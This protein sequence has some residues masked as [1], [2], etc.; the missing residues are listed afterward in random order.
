MTNWKK[1]DDTAAFLANTLGPPPGVAIILGSGLGDVGA[2]LS[3]EKSV[4]F[5]DIPGWPASTVVGHSGTLRRG[6]LGGAEVA[7]QLG[8][9]HLY[10][11]YDPEDVVLPVRSL[12]RWGAGTIILT[13]AAGGINENY[14]AG[15][16]MVVEDHLNLTGRNPL[17]GPNDDSR[18][19]RFPDMS[20]IYDANL[21]ANALDVA[22]RLDLSLHLGVY[23]GLTGPSYETPAEIR[24]LRKLGADAVGMSTVL[25]AI[26]AR[27]L[28]A[29]V[30][31]ISCI[32][33]PAA[34]I[35]DATLSHDDVRMFAARAAAN[36]TRLIIALLGRIGS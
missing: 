22:S 11:G 33:N 1:V 21:R 27:H 23:A 2:G 3:G 7:L 13:N 9:I 29:R 17:T 36:M 14:K 34:G 20:E 30:I 28:G 16:L 6:L 12:I 26:A 15:S 10:E 32:T 25:E 19:P 31:G 4:S 35:K 8:R 5:A 24:M 18:G